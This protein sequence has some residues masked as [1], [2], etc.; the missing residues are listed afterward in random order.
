MVSNKRDNVME[1]IKKVQK[2]ILDIEW[3]I[4]NNIFVEED[5]P[6]MRI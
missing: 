4:R 5:V 2:Q 3:E 1:E 6:Q